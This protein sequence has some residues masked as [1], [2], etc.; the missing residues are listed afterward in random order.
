MS[1]STTWI[2]I[3]LGTI[4][5]VWLWLRWRSPRPDFTPLQTAPDDPLMIAAMEKARA[6]LAEFR[7][8]LK[9]EHDGALVKVR[10]VSSSEQVEHLWAEVI[11][12]W[13][14]LDGPDPVIEVRLV[15]PPVT[16]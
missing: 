3:A 1:G 8:L 6:S 15:T 11:G 9:K 14:D 2:W 13:E 7:L 10:F 4:A 5:A 16:H 12:G